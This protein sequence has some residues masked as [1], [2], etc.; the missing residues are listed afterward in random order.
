MS[1]THTPGPWTAHIERFSTSIQIGEAFVSA[2][3]QPPNGRGR[4]PQQDADARLIAAAPD[5]L[6]ACEAAI[7]TIEDAE[8]TANTNC[9]P[10][11]VL[12][13]AAIAKARATP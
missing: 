11:L 10:T 1:N 3:Y 9:E 13:R 7:E 2:P 4:C 6:A 5:L 12:L 8:N